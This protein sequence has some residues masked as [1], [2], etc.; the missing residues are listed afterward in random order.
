MKNSSL[1]IFALSILPLSSFAS[2]DHLETCKIKSDSNA[3]FEEKIDVTVSDGEYFSIWAVDFTNLYGEKFHLAAKLR[4]GSVGELVTLA[5][6]D[7]KI[8]AYAIVRDLTKF[9][10][11]LLVTGDFKGGKTAAGDFSCPQKDSDLTDM[12]QIQRSFEIE[13]KIP[14]AHP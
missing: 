12:I 2:S 6:A 10:G 14:H 3:F 13:T 9:E 1:V 5:T 4:E 7:G 8:K 11:T